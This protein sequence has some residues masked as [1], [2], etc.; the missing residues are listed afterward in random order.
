MNVM[1]NKN[2][3]IFKNSFFLYILTFSNYFI[4]LLLYPYLSRTLTVENFGLVGFSM[5]FV[6]IFQV[7]VEFGFMISATALIARHRS[8]SEKVSEIISATML[9]KLILVIVSLLLFLAL[10]LIIPMVR[11]HFLIV[12][13]FFTSSIITAMLP[14]FFFRGIERMQSITIRTVGAKLVSL[15]IVILFMKNDSQILLVPISLI[16]GNCA[17]LIIAFVTMTTAGI[18]LRRVP[19]HDVILSIKGSLLFFF[20]RLAVSINGSLGAFFL[21]LK[22][23]PTSI[24]VGIFAG[25]T[26]LSSAGEMMLAPIIDSIYPHMVNK[27]DYGLFKKALIYGTGLWLITCLLVFIFADMI[28]SIILGPKYLVA[29]DYLRVLLISMFFA[30][31]NMMLGF[32]ALSPIGKAKHANIGN[33][34]STGINVIACIILWLTGNISLISICQVITL[35][36][37]TMLMYRGTMFYKFRQLIVIKSPRSSTE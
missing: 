18:Q 32:P 11:A 35:S 2:N 26:R 12:F 37:V 14:D 16:I 30:F 6:L 31:P 21:G 13:L 29:G 28:C 34:V 36:N 7:I 8:N 22:F 10:S 4:G 25:A 5:S 27:R 24:E 33:F 23:L 20:S 17:S 1:S 15:L 3:R 19:I 9:A